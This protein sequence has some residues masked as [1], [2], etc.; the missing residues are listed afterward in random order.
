MEI[1]IQHYR[2]IIGGVEKPQAWL[3]S[4]M[5]AGHTHSFKLTPQEM[6][7]LEKA[8]ERA[9]KAPPCEGAVFLCAGGG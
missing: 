2:E 5:E 9:K 8:V 7:D 4:F 1:K 6:Y 3:V